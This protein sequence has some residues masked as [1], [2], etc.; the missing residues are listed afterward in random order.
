MHIAVNDPGRMEGLLD[1]GGTQNKITG[2]G[3]PS[4][5]G[6]ASVCAS[7]ALFVVNER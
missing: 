6:A 7:C 3:M 5:Y 1:W 2:C 4:T